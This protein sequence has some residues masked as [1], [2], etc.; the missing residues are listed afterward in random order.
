MPRFVEIIADQRPFPYGL[1]EAGRTLFSCNFSALADAPA[2]ISSGATMTSYEESIVGILSS[3]GLA[4]LGTDTFIGPGVAIPAGVGP[5]VSL[6]D[7]GGLDPM[8]AHSGEK[9]ERLTF[10]IV[11]RATSYVAARSRALLIW[12]ALDGVRNSTVA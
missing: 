9:Y 5:Y 8:E 4:T 6:I 11:V 10:Q 12:D 2:W 1:D 7:M 3:A